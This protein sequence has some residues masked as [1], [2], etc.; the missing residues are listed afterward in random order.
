[1]KA[2]RR[3]GYVKSTPKATRESRFD[4]RVYMYTS[5]YAASFYYSRRAG[6]TK[7]HR[8][9]SFFPLSS[10]SLTKKQTR[11]ISHR[12]VMQATLSVKFLPSLTPFH[13]YYTSI[14]TFFLSLQSVQR[15]SDCSELG[16]DNASLVENL[17]LLVL[18]TRIV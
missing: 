5:F 3:T 16:V 13:Y 4:N 17:E 12:R 10:R 7:H 11:A 18:T 2:P 1:M 14:I 8:Q 6:S 9:S 15:Q